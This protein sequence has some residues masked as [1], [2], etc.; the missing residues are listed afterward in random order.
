MLGN[1]FIFMDWGLGEFNDMGGNEDC[2]FFLFN[3][4]YIWNDLLCLINLFYIC[5]K[6]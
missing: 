5:E 3:I 4:G 1:F 6:L 2:M